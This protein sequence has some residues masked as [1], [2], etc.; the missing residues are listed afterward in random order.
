MDI[1]K[2]MYPLSGQL[3]T[4]KGIATATIID[5]E[6]DA[7]ECVFNNAE[8]VEINTEGMSHILLDLKSLQT[9]KRLILESKK[10]YDT[11]F[12]GLESD[13]ITPKT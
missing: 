9:L 8:C 11:Y 13:G 3:K 2:K 6:L 4:K 7:Y 10:Y 5:V 1:E 12:D